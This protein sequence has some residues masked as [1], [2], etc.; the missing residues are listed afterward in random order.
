VRYATIVL[1]GLLPV[2]DAAADPAP[3]SPAATTLLG[4]RFSIRFPIGMEVMANPRDSNGYALSSRASTRAELATHNARVIAIASE[5]YTIAGKDLRRDVRADLAAQGGPLA[6][7]AITAI[8]L[9]APL[10][11]IAVDPHLPDRSGESNLIHAAYIADADGAVAIVAFYVMGDARA[12]PHK[13]AKR[14]RESTATIRAG[15]VDLGSYPALTFARF[16]RKQLSLTA[17]TGWRAVA[18]PGGER[19]AL[20]L[21]KLV[22]L[23][24]LGPSCTLDDGPMTSPASARSEA[25]RMLRRRVAWRVWAS[26]DTRRAELEVSSEHA[27]RVHVSCTARSDRALREAR[28]I[29]ESVAFW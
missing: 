25:A 17:P 3:L 19:D 7:A 12:E 26:G 24:T 15:K 23:G 1:A 29:I 11:G 27:P 5:S 14:A 18:M 22:P 28:A 2:I 4:E 21:R 9:E 16:G 10:R 13:W 6:S 8:A 20:L